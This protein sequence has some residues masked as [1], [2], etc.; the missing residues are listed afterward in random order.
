MAKSRVLFGAVVF[1]ATSIAATAFAA[2]ITDA[3]VARTS[4]DTLTITW[5]DADA[6]DVFVSSDPAAAPKAA[7]LISKLDADGRHQV[8]T[9]TVSRQYFLLRDAKSG[10][11]VRVAERAVPLSQGSN[12]RDIGGYP[13]ADGKQVRWGVLYR[14]GGT[15]LLSDSDVSMVK[16]LGIKDMV[17]L[18]SSEERV[19]APTRLDGIPYAAVGYSIR[20]IMAARP[21]ANTAT[22]GGAISQID[23]GAAYRGFPTLLT[24]QIKLLFAHMLGNEGPIAYNCA[25]GQDRTGFTTA[26]V[27]SVLGVPRDVIYKDY[28]LSVTYRHPEFEMP[29][30]DDATAA[31]NPAAAMFAGYQRDPAYARPQ[32][33]QDA[34]GTPYLAAAMDEVEKR[35]GSIDNFLEK[36]IGLTPKNRERLRA[37][38]LTN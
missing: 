2:N 12:F 31:T 22:T 19:L 34:S 36:E 18:R 32:P 17:D 28:L 23:M 20:Q 7:K 11:I 33:L 38:Y 21:A 4:A 24:P 8:T 25:A 5:T 15:P 3:N 27:L 1:A 37:M 29:K 13:G 35:W 10:Q 14:S 30:I 9:D 26:M 6:V 16:S